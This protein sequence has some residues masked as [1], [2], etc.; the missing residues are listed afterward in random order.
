MSMVYYSR[1]RFVT[2]LLPLLLASP[3]SGR[4]LSVF[5]PKL[6]GKVLPDELSLRDPKHFG[7][8]Y[9]G[10]HIVQMT[11]FF[12]EN[13]AKRNPGRISLAH[14]YPGIV[15]TNAV[16]KGR[17][18]TWTRYLWHYA[19]GP[20]L[21]PFATPF[22]ETGE[23]MLFI[24]SPRF[25]ARPLNSTVGVS[26]GGGDVEIAMSSDGMVGGGA[27]RVTSNGET[28]PTGKAY[29]EA[30]KAGMYEKVWDHT[31]KAFEVIEAGNVFTE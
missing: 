2:K 15:M 16:D 11:T 9:T 30:R 27:Y 14:V 8:T 17:L 7:F 22:M 18:P 12:M 21:R 26:K 10:S 20:I 25:P 24:T 3:L 5:N 19:M 4:V 31:M 6:E 28:F 1:M 13:I 29:E 23:R